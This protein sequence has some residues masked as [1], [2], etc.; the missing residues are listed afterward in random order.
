I[1]IDAVG[2][3][4]SVADAIAITRP[5]GRVV[6]LGMPESARIDL[7]GLWH[8]ETEM[9]GAY[10]YGTETL[11][12]GRT[13]TSFEMA[14]DLVASANLEQLVSARY[15]LNRYREAIAHAAEAGSRGA[16]KVVFEQDV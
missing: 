15:P 16:I 5:R 9:V 7:T 3:P 14:F 12:G 2:N 4:G 1:T 11:H 8:R 6:L 10:T 13:A